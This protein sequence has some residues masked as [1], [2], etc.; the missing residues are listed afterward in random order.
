MT[1]ASHENGAFSIIYQRT[2]DETYTLTNEISTSFPTF[3]DP[4]SSNI[5]LE[6]Y[7]NT[8]GA[9]QLLEFTIYNQELAVDDEMVWLV[10]FPSYYY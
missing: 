9:E 5:T 4:I 10:N 8:E 6:A 1:P 2:Y 3:E 7:F